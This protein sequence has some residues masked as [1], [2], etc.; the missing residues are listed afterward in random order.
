MV[1]ERVT[2]ASPEIAAEDAWAYT[3]EHLRK[4]EQAEEDVRAGRVVRM[5]EHELEQWITEHTDDGIA[6]S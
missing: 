5:T 3:P 1:D 6:G 2:E 4:V